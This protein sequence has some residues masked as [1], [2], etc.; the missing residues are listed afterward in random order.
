MTREEALS[1]VSFL[2]DDLHERRE[3]NSADVNQDDRLIGF[4]Q[5]FETVVVVVRSHRPGIRLTDEV[6]A[7]LARHYLTEIGWFGDES[8]EAAFIF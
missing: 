4:H 1:F 5:A 7:I 8:L 2:M 6:A 3:A